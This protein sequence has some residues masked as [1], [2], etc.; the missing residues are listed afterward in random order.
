VAFLFA[1]ITR[2]NKL[3]LLNA[4]SFKDLRLSQSV[5]STHI[6]FVLLTSATTI[7]R[8]YFFMQQA[9]GG[10]DNSNVQYYVLNLSIIVFALLDIALC[11]M[12][13]VI[14]HETKHYTLVPRVV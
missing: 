4:E 13:C 10:K 2:L 7:A 6:L 14:V 9:L 12:I 5:S 11:A 3:L 8:E 1:T